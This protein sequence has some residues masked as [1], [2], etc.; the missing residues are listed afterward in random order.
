MIIS[1]QSTVKFDS[2]FWA[3]VQNPL[4]PRKNILLSRGALL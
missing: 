4:K 3:S 1:G 2:S